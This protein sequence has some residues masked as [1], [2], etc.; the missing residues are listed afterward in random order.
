MEKKLDNIRESYDK[1]YKGMLK[2]GELPFFSTKHGFYSSIPF[3]DIIVLLDKLK[4]ED[5][6]SFIDLGSG[7][8]KLVIMA[9]L[10]TK[11]TGVEN[12]V[13]IFRDSMR[14]KDELKSNAVFLFE[15]Y[16]NVDLSKYDVIFINPD[17]RLHELEKK[18]RREMKGKLV[19]YG[20]LYEPLN[21][22]LVNSFVLRGFKVSVYEN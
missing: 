1:Y 5:C 17:R 2:N 4:L 9:A 20:G 6:K 12:D 19:V 3:Y 8:G 13:G 11:A 22:K 18:L 21:L 15:D 14:K 16:I 7:D 10:I